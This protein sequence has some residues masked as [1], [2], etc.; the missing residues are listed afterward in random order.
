[1]AKKAKKEKATVSG[2]D[3]AQAAIKKKF[4]E[5]IIVSGQSIVEAPK[6]LIPFSPAHD[7]MLGGGIPEGTWTIV[8][9][10][11]KVGK[12]TSALDFAGTCQR[13]EYDSPDSGPRK[14]FFFNVEGR[15]K[16][17]D[18]RGIKHLILSDDRFEVVKSKKG[19]ILDAADYL[20]IAETYINEVPGCVIVF[21]SFSQLCSKE[22]K[23]AE[24]GE[25][26]RD[27]V[28]LMLS[29]FCKRMCN[30]L[31]VNDCIFLGI[32]H[33]IANQAPGAKKQTME[34]GGRKIQYNSDIKMV[35]THRTFEPKEG[36]AK[37]QIIH[38]KCEWAAS[39]APGGK[40]DSFLRYDHGIDKQWE[41]IDM[42]VD[43]GVIEKS[44]GWYLLPGE[45]KKINGKDKVSD[46]LRENP[47]LFDAVYAQCRE[48]LG[49]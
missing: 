44:G 28:P 12:T 13:P 47:L 48:M 22:R 25:R 5:G 37:G 43:L 23:E 7:L 4:G 10:P 18:L 45:D 21:D 19:K 39:G 20:E 38:W 9:G 26:F 17:R 2:S 14:V 16:D 41:V 35:A 46:Y 3:A 15:L 49:L 1:M 32:T 27:D 42:G 34:A 30:V 33:L 29:S 24:V 40:C 8:T 11:P 31:P 36:V 6:M